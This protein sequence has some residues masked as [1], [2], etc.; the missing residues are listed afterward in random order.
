MATF[1]Y[2]V[3]NPQPDHVDEVLKG[4]PYIK[5]TGDAAEFVKS[6][7]TTVPLQGNPVNTY[8]QTYA[9][10]DRT[11]AARQAAAVTNN[12]TGTPD[13][14]IVDITDPADTPASADALRDDL[15]ANALAEIRANFA[16]VADI[17]EKLRADQVDTA[18]L[19]NAVIDDLQTAEILD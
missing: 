12:V 7:G 8:T 10:A 1:I 9:T 13:A 4:S 6:D 11:H 16:D 19:L 17:L 15:V 18:Q 2:S 5:F 14:I 3:S